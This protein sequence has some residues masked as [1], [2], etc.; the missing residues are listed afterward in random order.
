MKNLSSII[1]RLIPATL[2]DSLRPFNNWVRSK[3]R[4]V[5]RIMMEKSSLGDLESDLRSIGIGEGDILMV[6]SSLSSIG[7]I[8]GSADTVVESLLKTVTGSGTILMPAY[9]SAESIQSGMSEDSYVDLRVLKSSMG[10][11]TDVFRTW[12]GVIR[13]SHP[14]SS[15]CALGEQA[16]YVTSKHETKP[17]ICH[18]ESPMARIIEFDA[19]IVGIG[20][21]IAV[22]MAVSH[23]LEDTDETFPIEVHAPAFPVKYIDGT[24]ETVSRKVVRYDPATSATRIGSRGTDWICDMLTQHFTQLGIMQHFKFGKADSWLMHA[25]PVHDELKRLAG[26][27]ITIYLTKEQWKSMNDGDEGI[28]SW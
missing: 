21:S 26:K 13:S 2:L 19:K 4:V 16:E 15:V 14:F 7:N 3:L 9:G 12:P 1:K 24:G 28:D 6:H 22:G 8:D 20:V 27:N 17:Y 25:K 11:I 5:K 10:K 23:Y 18:A